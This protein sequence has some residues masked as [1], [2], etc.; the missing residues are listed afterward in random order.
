MNNSLIS[1]FV[2][3]LT[4]YVNGRL[5][6]K[7]YDMENFIDIPTMLKDCGIPGSHEWFITDYNSD[8]DVDCGEYPS[9]KDLENMHELTELASEYNSDLIKA[10]FCVYGDLQDVIDNIGEAFIY[11]AD[12]LDDLGRELLQ[13]V[14][15]EGKLGD[16]E[17]YF[18]YAAYA[19]MQIN[20]G[21][22]TDTG[23]GY[24]NA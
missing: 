2:T 22:I 11:E 7:W 18:D 24:I 3:D 23:Y 6:G 20:S 8:F 15:I 9:K 12:N 14:D 5:I 1:I 17:Y 13:G 19:E 4:E 10:L 16:L 21:F